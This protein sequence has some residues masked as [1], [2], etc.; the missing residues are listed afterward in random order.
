MEVDEISEVVE[1][2]FGFH[3]IEAVAIREGDVPIAEAKQE[4]AE[5]LYRDDWLAA[6]ARKAAASTLG[7]W[8]QGK[9]DD[10]IA[11]E[12]EAAAEKHGESALTPTLEETA[13]FGHADTPVPGLSTAALLDAVFAL[14]EGAAFPSAPVKLGREWVIFRLIDRE[15]P[16]EAAF[17]DEVREST[18]EVLR[19]LKKQETVDLYIRQLRAKATAD[20]ALRVNALPS[21]DGRS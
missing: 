4:L 11:L 1:T 21:Q 7:S 20:K 10:A 8:Q 9:D 19:T 12:L 14:P 13:E 2:P 15:R 5:G 3:V 17:T 16:D 6:R 18:R